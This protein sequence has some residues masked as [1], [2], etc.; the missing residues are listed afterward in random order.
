MNGAHQFQT[1]L[2]FYSEETKR[3]EAAYAQLQKQFYTLKEQFESSLQTLEAIV[4]HL[5]DGLIF[6]SKEG[7]ITLFNPAAAD[8]IGCDAAPLLSAPYWDHF[9]DALFGFSMRE[10]LQERASHKR[11][12]V[13]LCEERELEVS[14]SLI[15]EKGILLLLS[16]RQ[17]REALERSAAQTERLKELGEMAATLA[18]E[19]RNPLGGIEGFAQLLKRDLETPAHQ[20]MIKAILEG[21]QTL[22]HL[23]TQVLDYARPFSLHFVT[24]DLVELIQ[25]TIALMEASSNH[26]MCRLV[27]EYITFPCLIDENQ[28]KRVLLN[29]LRNAKEAKA[30]LVEI[31]LTQE[32]TL[33][34]KDNGEGIAAHNLKK[35]FTPFFTTKTDGTG[36]GLAQAAAV[37]KAHGGTLEVFSEEGKGT[38]FRLKI[39]G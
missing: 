6:I 34:I 35:I 20:R 16:N 39:V 30:N 25:E 18:H 1:A 31:V 4:T 24:A 7:N 19:I 9:S 37:I 17:E 38:E 12:F 3:V 11:I 29:L 33:V 5:S 21:T 23:V 15:P 28:I 8:L 13:T 10:A 14:T 32:G 36:L 27:T 22:N 26:P 2:S